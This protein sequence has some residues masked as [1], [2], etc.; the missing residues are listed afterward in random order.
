MP[1]P[2]MRTL[3][4]KGV[5]VS[6]LVTKA[7]LGQSCGCGNNSN[8][9]DNS[10]INNNSSSN[11]KSKSTSN[12]NDNSNSN[13][14]S[15][16]GSELNPELCTIEFQL[17]LTTCCMNTGALKLPPRPTPINGPLFVAR[18]GALAKLPALI[19]KPSWEQKNNTIEFNFN[20]Y[21]I[22]ELELNF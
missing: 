21:K 2:T 5:I 8:S 3:G 10:S 13:S 19:M 22:I 18:D 11:S 6:N 14:S 15:A 16:S 4:G 7:L 9:N 17:V 20:N 1:R 12:D